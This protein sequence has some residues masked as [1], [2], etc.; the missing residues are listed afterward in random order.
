MDRVDFVG[1]IHGQFD[2]FLE[3]LDLLGYVFCNEC[4]SHPENRKLVILGDL[5]DR[6][7]KNREV[8]RTVRSL[9]DQGVAVCLMGNH[10]FNAVLFHTSTEEGTFLRPHTA[11][12]RKQHETFLNEFS[13]CEDE[14]ASVIEWFA[15][16]PVAIETASF[17]AV[18]ACWADEHLNCFRKEGLG[19]YMDSSSWVDASRRQSE[20]DVAIEVLLKGPERELPNR[21]HFF[22]KGNVKR[23]K[24]RLAWWR[25]NPKTWADAVDDSIDVVELENIGWNDDSFHYS[26]DQKPVFFGHYWRTG[27]PSSDA[28]NA[29]CLDYSAGNGGH[30]TAYRF[31]SRFSCLREGSIFQVSTNK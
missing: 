2:A 31:E 8:I 13:E 15:S 26:P 3:I 30:L 1:D 7:T 11:K 9:V 22:D 28:K 20:M 21:L 5:I 29:Y 4:W 24:A 10:E 14:W 16:L 23:S 6:G 19:W 27:E 18:H 17:R 12:N 25:G